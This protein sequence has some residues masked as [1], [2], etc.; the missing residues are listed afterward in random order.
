[1]NL[2]RLFLT[3]L[4]KQAPLKTKFR[5]HNNNPFMTK[6]LRKIIMTDRSSKIDTTK[7]IITKTGIYIKNKGISV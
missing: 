5:R 7:T 1:M 4:N 6:E 3:V 2:K